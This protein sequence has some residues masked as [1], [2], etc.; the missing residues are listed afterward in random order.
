[1]GKKDWSATHYLPAKAALGGS[2]TVKISHFSDE[3][4]ASGDFAGVIMYHWHGSFTWFNPHKGYRGRAFYVAILNTK[5]W[6]ADAF[7]AAGQGRVHD[8]IFKETFGES[9]TGN[10]ASVGGFAVRNGEVKFSSIW[11]NMTENTANAH[12]W[13]SDGSQ[14][15]S[16]PEQALVSFVVSEWKQRGTNVVCDIPA[17]LDRKLSG[18]AVSH[19]A[20]ETPSLRSRARPVARSSQPLSGGF[21]VGQAVRA[22]KEIKVGGTVAVRRSDRGEVT[23][24][25]TGEDPEERVNVRWG[26]RHDGKRGAINVL[27]FEISAVSSCGN[28]SS[29]DSD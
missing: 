21:Q 24:P 7:R 10:S 19:L 25:A 22:T 20:V 9:Y 3:F 17:Q 15:L 13:Y 2:V 27:V 11:L 18:G 14:M 1:M 16:E 28:L 23:G 29:S 8:F 4:D 12:K 6:P 26:C 5:T